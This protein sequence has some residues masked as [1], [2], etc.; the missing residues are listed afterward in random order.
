MQ[1]DFFGVIQSDGEEKSQAL[2]MSDSSKSVRRSIFKLACF[3]QAL[4]N[5]GRA[6][7]FLM[8]SLPG[9]ADF[10]LTEAG[11]YDSGKEGWVVDSVL[12]VRRC[13][14]SRSGIFM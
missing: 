3:M 4:G 5:L 10:K 6:E 14:S 13:S 11:M 2:K 9:A 12:Y 8:V 7:F 1:V